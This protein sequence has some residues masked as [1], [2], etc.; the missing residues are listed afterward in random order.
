[1][2]SQKENSEWHTKRQTGRAKV[3]RNLCQMMMFPSVTDFKKATKMNFIHNCPVTV[4]DIDVAEDIFGKDICA[5]KGKTVRKTPCNV[6]IDTIKTPKETMKSH[7][8]T[9]SGTDTMHANGLAFFIT[10]SSKIKFVTV[11]EIKSR[12]MKMISKCIEGVIQIHNKRNRFQLYVK[13][14]QKSIIYI[15]ILFLSIEND[16]T[17]VIVPIFPF[18]TNYSPRP[19]SFTKLF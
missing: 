9:F 10:V 8:D 15:C 19:R 4:D 13:Y 3:A 14:K 12:S 1:M 6:T 16:E 17:L 18:K 11:E 5:L 7:N 2:Q